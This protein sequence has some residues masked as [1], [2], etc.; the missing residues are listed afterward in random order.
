MGISLQHHRTFQVVKFS[1][2]GSKVI[3]AS[4]DHT[5]RIWDAENGE[6][7]TP[8]LQE[9]DEILYAEF[10]P[11]GSRAVTGCANGI[12]RI[13]DTATG[14]ALSEPLRHKGKVRI[15]RFSPD[16]QTIAAACSG[17]EN[18]VRLWHVPRAPE[19]VPTWAPDLADTI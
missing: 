12:V 9:E 5:A 8:P 2:D 17:L 4:L 10:S 3:T 15:V 6:T 13:W 16:G 7:L 18:G 19:R 11:D 1:H 14:L